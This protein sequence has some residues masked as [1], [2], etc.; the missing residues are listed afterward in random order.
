[1]PQ[2]GKHPLAPP[3]SQVARL[4]PE[5]TLRRR[6][7]VAVPATTISFISS[8]G[9]DQYK[10][11]RFSW[12]GIPCVI[13]NFS[14]LSKPIPS[15]KKATSPKT[16]MAGDYLKHWGGDEIIKPNEMESPVR[17]ISYHAALA[18]CQ[19]IGG[20][21]PGMGHFSAAAMHDTYER[22]LSIT[23]EKP[24]QPSEFNFVAEE[25]TIG[26]GTTVRLGYYPDAK[27]VISI[28]VSTPA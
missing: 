13:A 17:Y 5:S 14:P 8:S 27:G 16:C 20:T 21:L 7:S 28:F 10:S 2:T 11:R 25:W 12:T 3:L 4:E 19:T 22:S 15:G 6:A 26:P 24:Y 1:M 23:Y 18:Y 9:W